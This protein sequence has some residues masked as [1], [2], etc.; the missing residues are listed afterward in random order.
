M[1]LL[2]RA[3]PGRMSLSFTPGTMTLTLRDVRMLPS[4]LRACVMMHSICSI[5]KD[6]KG[7]KEKQTRGRTVGGSDKP[8][9]SR[10]S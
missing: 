7:A 2:M 3:T 6:A 4:N 8:A 1:L 5:S 9:R 10:I